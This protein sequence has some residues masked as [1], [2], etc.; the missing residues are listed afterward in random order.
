MILVFMT[1]EVLSNLEA[2]ALPTNCQL[3]RKL[4][5]TTGSEDYDTQPYICILQEEPPT[6]IEEEIKVFTHAAGCA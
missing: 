5:V 4:L 2:A 1:V 3:S 6:R